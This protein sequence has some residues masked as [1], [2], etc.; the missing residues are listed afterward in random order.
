MTASLPS[1]PNRLALAQFLHVTQRKIQPMTKS[2]GRTHISCAIPQSRG[3]K[4]IQGL[5]RCWPRKV[6]VFNIRVKNKFIKC[7]AMKPISN[8]TVECK[9]R[10]SESRKWKVGSLSHRSI[11]LGRG[12]PILLAAHRATV[13]SN[14]IG[15]ISGNKNFPVSIYSYKR[16]SYTLISYRFY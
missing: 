16:C 4:R 6:N 9:E 15:G 8:S 11:S 13:C 2:S 7:S 1:Q 12:W 10:R 3:N 5:R 14:L